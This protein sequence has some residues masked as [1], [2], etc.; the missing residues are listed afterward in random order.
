MTNFALWFEEC[1][2][3]I[4]MGYGLGIGF[5]KC[6][7]DDIIVFSLI[8]RDHILHD[9]YEVFERFKEHNLKLHLGKCRFF[10]IEIEY[11][12]HILYLNGSWVHKAKVKTIPH[13]L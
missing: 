4:P 6:Y 11:L 7:I 12:G 9:M 2:Y 5:A 13:V 1:P 10:H 8:P 3:K